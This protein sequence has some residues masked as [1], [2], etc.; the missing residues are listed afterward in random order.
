[1]IDDLEEESGSDD[2]DMVNRSLASPNARGAEH[3]NLGNAS[4]ANDE[5]KVD[6]VPEFVAESSDDSVCSQ[7]RKRV[8]IAKKD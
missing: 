3:F 1:M 4:Q 7:R 2:D 6:S 5:S 8:K